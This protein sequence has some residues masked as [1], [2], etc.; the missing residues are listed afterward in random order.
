M[1][2]DLAFSPILAINFIAVIFCIL[3]GYWIEKYNNNMDISSD[4]LDDITEMDEN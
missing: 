2:F 3:K 1:I 4:I